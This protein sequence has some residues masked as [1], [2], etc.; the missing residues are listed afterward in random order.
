MLNK[1]L[2]SNL[3][4]GLG[5]I[6]NSAAL[7]LLVPY[8][9]NNLSPSEFGVWSIIEITIMILTLFISAGLDVGLMREYW[10]ITDEQY[11]ATLAGTVLIAIVVW[12]ILLFTLL[13]VFSYMANL[14][15]YFHISWSVVLLV[16]L[17]ACVETL[18]LFALNLFRIREDPAKFVVL[19]VGRLLLFYGGQLFLSRLALD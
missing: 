6:A 15:N 8:L 5:S 16:L 18:F 3:I 19:S 10:A 1:T 2:K 17:V 9:V 7:F 4:Y 12:G 11:R 14:Q 13:S